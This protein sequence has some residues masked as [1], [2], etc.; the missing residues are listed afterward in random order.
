MK[1]C[2]KCGEQKPIDRFYW[3][4]KRD[5]PRPQCIPCFKAKVYETRTP[6]T[7]EQNARRA[8]LLR[9]NAPDHLKPV[10]VYIPKVETMRLKA[11]WEAQKK[12]ERAQAQRERKPVEGTKA[13][14]VTATEEQVAVYRARE[15]SAYQ[16]RYAK[17][18]EKEI[19]RQKKYK[20]ANCD[21]IREQNKRYR[22]Q[23]DGLV[24]KRGKLHNRIQSIRNKVNFTDADQQR[25]EQIK[26]EIAE[27]NDRREADRQHDAAMRD[28]ALESITR[29][30]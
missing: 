22:E 1:T 26:R 16:V 30:V 17:N 23:D 14:Y 18:R 21:K 28:L 11:E 19:E 12:V 6:R 5:A 10:R 27:I 20:Q 29:A 15:R 24:K 2:S 3:S 8:E 9:L 25:I 4:K 13:W 7:P